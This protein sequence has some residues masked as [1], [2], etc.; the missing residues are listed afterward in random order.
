[1]NFLPDRLPRLL[2]LAMPVSVASYVW[3][4]G[5]EEFYWESYGTLLLSPIIY[6]RLCPPS[7]ALPA[8]RFLLEHPWAVMALCGIP[9]ALLVLA[10]VLGV[11][12]Y[13]RNSL[14]ISSMALLLT[15]AVF[16]T[17]HFL[18]PLGFTVFAGDGP[19]VVWP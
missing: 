7:V 12:A 17:Y 18:Q 1:M 4:V 8:G 6:L 16:T 19:A 5:W 13:W 15:L 3:S 14:L 2:V 9:V 10:L 11:C